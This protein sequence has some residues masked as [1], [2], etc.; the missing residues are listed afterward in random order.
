MDKALITKQ[1]M[2][3]LGITGRDNN[4]NITP[5]QMMDDL[6][7]SINIEQL[8]YR[9]NTSNLSN[10]VKESEIYKAST[11]LR[12]LLQTNE[13]EANQQKERAKKYGDD[14]EFGTISRFDALAPAHLDIHSEKLKLIN[15]ELA[16]YNKPPLPEDIKPSTTLISHLLILLQITMEQ[17]QNHDPEYQKLV[18]R[19]LAK[20]VD[21][22][23][24][25]RVYFAYRI[26]TGKHSRYST[27]HNYTDEEYLAA[28][29]KDES[30]SGNFFELVKLLLKKAGKHLKD[31]TIKKYIFEATK[32]PI[33]TSDS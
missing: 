10:K 29:S 12:L 9:R 30:I 33:H 28:G 17:L 23:F 19:R 25:T 1:E 14:P 15:R 11:K 16:K 24:I 31:S 4:S 22:E 7:E 27:K 2:A 6:T 21:Q 3:K 20:Q 26:Y 32:N 5:D 13:K 8:F 18:D